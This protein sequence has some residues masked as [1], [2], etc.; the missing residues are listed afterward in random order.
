M[1]MTKLKEKGKW[2]LKIKGK[3]SWMVKRKDNRELKGK[4]KASGEQGKEW[5]YDTE[6]KMKYSVTILKMWIKHKWGWWR[7]EK[8]RREWGKKKEFTSAVDYTW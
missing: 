6:F 2:E 5:S 4:G 1:W 3:D 7:I 8:I